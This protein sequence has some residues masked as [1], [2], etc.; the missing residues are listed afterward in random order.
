MK[1]VAIAASKIPSTTANS[2]QVMKTCQALSL[3]GHEVVLLTPKTD[4]V[5]SVDGIESLYGLRQAF[6]IHPI[7]YFPSFR[8]YDFSLHAAWAAHKMK[9]E[10]IYCWLIQAAVFAVLLRH[11]VI[12]EMHG[13]PEGRIGP[14][15]FRLFLSLP[16]RKRILFIT[17]ALQQIVEQKF[18]VVFPPEQAMIAPNGVDLD[19]Y[20]SLPDP[21]PARRS[22][23]LPDRFSA[24]YT[25]H[26]YPGRGMSL[27]LELAQRFP[28]VS[29]VWVGGHPEDVRVWKE[30]IV[31]K[32]LENV[33]LTG[34][35]PN[36]R[37]AYYQAAGDVLLMPY[38]RTIAGSSGGNSADY[39]SPMKMFEYM[40]CRR[41]I[42]TS[43]LPVIREVLN[44]QNALLCPP[45]AV[46]AWALG[47]T[48]LINDPDLRQRLARRAWQDVQ[49]FTWQARLQ[50]ALQGF[51][52]G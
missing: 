3:S 51:P 23:G 29:F 45:E 16:G 31:Q 8:R 36:D 25:G 12:L 42:L 35:V 40:A 39:C 20:Q 47:L 7:K 11:P 9:A 30:R 15:L 52:P 43:D 46:E 28:E 14:F 41:P 26:L 38:E 4:G 18:G 19:R 24:I 5:G 22:L 32:G 21:S 48:Q 10:L 44:E 27:L 2:I 37:L 34:F 13:P 17:R 50:R 33:T 49:N 6:P 1:I